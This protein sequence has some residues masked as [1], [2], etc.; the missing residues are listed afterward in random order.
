MS[1][2]PD[3]FP[4]LTERPFAHRGLHG[5]RVSENGMAAFTAAIAGGFGIECDVR[6]SRDGVA[7]VFHDASLERMTG[8][9]GAVA[10]HDAAAIDRLMLPDGG[11]VPRLR[12][13]LDLCGTDIP[14]LV[15]IK[16]DG[17][18]VAP[19]CAAVADDL[20]RRPKTLAAVMS[21][22]PVAMR[23]FR[24]HRPMVA[25]G[26][27]VTGQ[28]RRGWRGAMGRALALWAA[29]PDF[30][31]CDIR[32]LPSPLS[33]RAR[34]RGMP[35]LTWTVRGEEERARAALHADQI[36]FERSHD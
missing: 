29:K 17:R 24:R 36:I 27:V 3:A 16:V 19:I 31:A 18:H 13:L 32:D 20:A 8:E 34:R 33:I 15:E 28:D 12:A 6:L 5:G 14:L 25:C 1:A 30:I 22:N 2:R 10:D 9:S 4:F 35:V 26:L 7:I 21:F 11:G 23:W